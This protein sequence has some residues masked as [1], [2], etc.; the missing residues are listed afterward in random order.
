MTG[1]RA[2]GLAIYCAAAGAM[3]LLP[4]LAGTYY[5][6]V[7]LAL[8]SWIALAQSWVLLSGTT[9][10][11]SLGHA[12]FYGLGGY[13]TVLTWQQW[14]LWISLPAAGIAAALA[15]LL[16]GWPVLRVRGPYFVILT[17]GLAELMK[18][19]VIDIEAK[20]GKFGR[21]LM[22][23]PS[24]ETLYWIML[25]LALVATLAT[26]LVRR[27]RFG[28]GLRAIRENEEAAETLGVP[29][30]RFKLFA[31][32]ASAF[33]PGIV[34]GVMALRSAY[35]EPFQA[36]NPVTSFTIVVIAMIGGSD[37]APGPIFGALLLVILQELLWVHAPE[38]YL[39]IL[40]LVLIGFVLFVPEGLHGRLSRKR[41]VSA[42][43]PRERPR[44]HPA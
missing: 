30:V 21:L 17:Y 41:E 42:D 44:E 12:M 28:A 14:P 25:A 11:I 10:Y 8:L 31:F 20:L 39:I 4:F 15:A 5:L 33:I 32:A 24:L 23:A 34:G 27:S 19:I 36:F 22:G 9:G 29:V 3:A 16:L 40:G 7:G 2:S 13:L 18:F 38:L 26:Y 6:G 43:R 1:P 35:F 37:D